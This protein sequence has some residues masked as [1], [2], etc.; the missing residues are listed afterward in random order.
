MLEVDVDFSITLKSFAVGQVNQ[1]IHF[2]LYISSNFICS[3]AWRGQL[4]H[5]KTSFLQE[6]IVCVKGDNTLHNLLVST[7]RS[8]INFVSSATSDEAELIG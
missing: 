8:D 1:M 4:L 6:K 7:N 5:L 2:K 3:Q